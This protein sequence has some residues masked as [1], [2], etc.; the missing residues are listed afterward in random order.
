MAIASGTSLSFRL[1]SS[2]VVLMCG[3][4]ASFTYGVISNAS[5]IIH[6]A[7]FLLAATAGLFL[8]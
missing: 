6:G 7:L 3:G 5:F 8:I 2:A 4:A 1:F